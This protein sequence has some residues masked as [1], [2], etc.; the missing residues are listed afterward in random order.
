MLGT[1]E[2]WNPSRLVF[3][4]ITQLCIRR[5]G[6]PTS[7]EIDAIGYF[8]LQSLEMQSTEAVGTHNKV[9]RSNFMVF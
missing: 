5:L 9:L 2:K 3:I 4:Y 8:Q 1:S 6:A 7:D